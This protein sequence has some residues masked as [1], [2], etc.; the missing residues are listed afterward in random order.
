MTVTRLF[1]PPGYAPRLPHEYQFNLDNA[2]GQNALQ[3]IE[4]FLAAHTAS[5]Q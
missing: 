3:Q 1:Y 5:A 4:D 2:D